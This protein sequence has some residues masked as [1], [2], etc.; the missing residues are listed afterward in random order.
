M[1]AAA[2]AAVSVVGAAWGAPV[3][4]AGDGFAGSLTD[5]YLAGDP[6]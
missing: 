2:A 6:W 3:V 1:A 5:L 4:A